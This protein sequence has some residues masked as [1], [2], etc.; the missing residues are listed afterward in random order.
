MNHIRQTLVTIAALSMLGLAGCS[1][2]APTEEGHDSGRLTAS[3]GEHD[4]EGGEHGR[5]GD[6]EHGLEGEGEHGEES[7]A[8]LAL[9]ET[10][11]Q[12]RNSARLIL[13]YDAESNC[14]VGTVENI[15]NRALERVRVEVHLSNGKEL[16]PTT[17]VDLL[18]G[19]KRDVE[20]E[21]SGEGF[22]RWSAHPEVGS[23]EHG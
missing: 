8:E 6:R 4:R 19:A 11:D 15:S 17:P 2:G 23:G 20:L 1:S 10:Y 3:R 13:R 22:E 7:G 5:E 12:V 9:G 21:A 16:G 14:F 18:P